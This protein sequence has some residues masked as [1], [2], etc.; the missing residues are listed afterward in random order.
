LTKTS[1]ALPPVADKKPVSTTHHGITINDDY[2]WLRA[3]NWQEVMQQPETL[4]ATIRTHLEAENAY[5]DAVM[6]DTEALRS[7]LFEEMKG[8]IKEDDISVPTPDGPY[9]YG[10]KFV[11]GAQ[12]PMLIR[13]PRNGG[14]ET[15]LLDGNKEAEGKDYFR[16]GGTA[17]SPDHKL[18]AW[19]H[20]DKGSEY[21]KLRFRD[22][23]SGEDLEDEILNTSGGCVWSADCR[24]VFYVLL[25]DNHRPSKLFRHTLGTPASEDVL[26]H[27]EKDPGF[28]MGVGH[29]QS[30]NCILIDCHDHETSEVWMIPADDPGAAPVVVA[31]REPG[32]E[33]SVDEADGT[34]YVLTNADDTEDFK[35]VT[36]PAAKPGR[37][38][39]TDLIPQTKDTLILSH[40]VLANHLIRLERSAGLPRIVIRRLSD[41]E[42]HAIAFDE[43]AYSLGVSTGYEFD[44]T[45]I[46]F[47]YS[48]MTTPSQVF[49]YDIETRER[50]LRKEQEV[51][52]GHDPANY[53]TRRVMAKA[54][55]GEEVPISLLYHKSTKLDGTA[56]GWMY[57][58]GSY[59]IAMPAGFSTSRLSL[60]DRGFVYAILHIRGGKEKGY[61][62][63]RLGKREHKQNTFK[64]FIAATRHLADEGFIDR[65]RIVAH[66]GSAGGMLMGAIS[67]MAPDLYRGIVADVPFVDVLNTMLDDTLPLTPPEWPEWGNPLASEDDFKTIAAYSPY[68]N[69]EA[70]DY[71][72]ILAVGGLTDPRVTYWEPAKWVAKLREMKTDDNLL[73]LKTHMDSG[74]GGAS[75]RFDS[76][77][78]VA[79]VYA[80]GLKVTG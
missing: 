49:D 52:S 39:W 7:T 69:V 77:K 15:L 13:T 58:Y 4:A 59:G 56:P 2:A 23:A 76:L 71:P 47:T 63:Y 12:H 66:G 60:V 24:H 11:T 40:T 72:N 16:F 57:G 5:T 38:N 65:N 74:H 9:A 17:H 27:E 36:A 20:D 22:V 32:V 18:L 28:F 75:G 68:D 21:H 14:E 33:Y 42:E 55:D 29:T 80:F 45:E 3:D 70:K 79:L 8:R 61:R 53:V 50:V 41:G 34:L 51:P 30:Q 31:Q 25:D 62:W 19:A 10:I 1:P 37:E 43:E 64:D 35:I 78:E 6:A 46:R 54:E 73:L 26:V 44:T 48:S 67:N